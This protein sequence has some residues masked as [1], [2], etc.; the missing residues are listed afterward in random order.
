[1]EY[2]GATA[3]SLRSLG[4]EMF[5]SYFAKGVIPADGNSG[6]MDEGLASWRDKGYQTLTHPG[7]DMF[8]LGAHSPY[9]RNTDKN[10][11]KIF[12]L[13]VFTSLIFVYSHRFL[14][15]YLMVI[16]V[17]LVSNRKDWIEWFLLVS[18]VSM[19]QDFAIFIDT[20]NILGQT[21]MAVAT[22]VTVISFLYKVTKRF[23]YSEE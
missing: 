23:S 21:V 5:H 15:W 7:Y 11:Y 12:L 8:N 16:P 2:P 3:T 10:S 18:F 17:F 22:I 14:P 9:K 4:H 6:W 19:F 1:M 13:I 20:S